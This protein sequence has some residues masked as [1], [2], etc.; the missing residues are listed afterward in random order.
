M[1]LISYTREESNGRTFWKRQIWV[2]EHEGRTIEL[3]EWWD[4]DVWAYESEHD[5]EHLGGILSGQLKVLELLGV[6]HD[7]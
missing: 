3:V 7:N 6:Q 4:G 2:Y 5:Y 1:R